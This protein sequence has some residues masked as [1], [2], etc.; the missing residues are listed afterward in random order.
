[1]KRATWLKA[2]RALLY[3]FALA[4][5]SGCGSGYGAGQIAPPTPNPVSDGAPAAQATG[6]PPP[7]ISVYPPAN[8][9]T[10]LVYATAGAQRTST[11]LSDSATSAAVVTAIAKTAPTY[12]AQQTIQAATYEAEMHPTP[13]SAH[14]ERGKAYPFVLFTHCGIDYVDFNGSFWDVLEKKYAP[15]SLGNPSQRGTMT[16]IEEDRAMFKFDNGYILFTRHLGP[17]VLAG[18]CA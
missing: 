3:A 7:V 9:A 8:S 18:P 14:V 10:A 17:K 16:L 4:Q 11:A 5:L 15:R 2:V 6:V 1:M 12:A 13:Q